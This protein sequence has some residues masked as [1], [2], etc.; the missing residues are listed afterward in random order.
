MQG[1]G[2]TMVVG[3]PA[4][5]TVPLGIITILLGRTLKGSVLGG[6]KVRSDLSIIADKCQKKVTLWH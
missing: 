5:P 3:I 6:L 1:T 4:E 2:K